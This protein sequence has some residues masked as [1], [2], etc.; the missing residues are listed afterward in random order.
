MK[1][2]DRILQRM[3]ISKAVQHLHGCA[4]VLDIG[5][6]D[7]ALFNQLD[8]VVGI[9]IDPHLQPVTSAPHVQLIQGFFPDALPDSKPFDGIAMLAVLEHLQPDAQKALA[10]A[11]AASLVDGGKMV[12][13]TPSPAVDAILDVLYFFRVIDAMGE[14]H[15]D[16]YG[17]NPV[18]TIPLFEQCGLRLIIHQRFQLGLNHLFVF[19]KEVVND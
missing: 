3:R 13:T 14:A 2:V 15:D 16:H 19:E 8:C 4:R 10:R 1:T 11:C 6:H 12:L 9:G 18:L 5:T 7:G 17:F